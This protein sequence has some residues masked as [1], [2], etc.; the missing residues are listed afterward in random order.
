MKVEGGFKAIRVVAERGAGE[1]LHL[2]FYLLFENEKDL[3]LFK[4]LMDKLKD[5]YWDAVKLSNDYLIEYSVSQKIPA[6]IWVWK[7]Y[8]HSGKVEDMG[9]DDMDQLMKRVEEEYKKVTEPERKVYI[10]SPKK[11]G[12]GE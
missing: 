11:E 6:A 5:R 4:K 10:I 7:V 3:E 9:W 12:G 2:G 8:K 1:T